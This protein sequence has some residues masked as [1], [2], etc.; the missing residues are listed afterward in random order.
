[1]VL[2]IRRAGEAENLNSPALE[3]WAFPMQRDRTGAAG[4]LV[5]MEGLPRVA[6]APWC[7]SVATTVQSRQRGSPK[8]AAAFTGRRCP[9]VSTAL[10]RWRSIRKAKCSG[11]TRCKESGWRGEEDGTHDVIRVPECEIGLCASW[12]ISTRSVS[13]N[14]L[15]GS[16]S[17]QSDTLE[18]P[19]NRRRSTAAGAD[20]NHGSPADYR[21]PTAP[22][23]RRT[24]SLPA[25]T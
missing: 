3:M 4:S 24:R 22:L 11:C 16:A 5:R 1:M 14:C 25:F 20:C 6:T 7:T 13:M 21:S 12:A 23:H 19:T 2:P 10:S 15:T 9:S 18:R 17:I 8:P